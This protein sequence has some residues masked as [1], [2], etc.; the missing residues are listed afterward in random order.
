M[1]RN[2]LIITRAIAPTWWICALWLLLAEIAQ[3]TIV[4]YLRIREVPPSFV[5]VTVIWYAIRVDSQR[6]VAFAL[7][8][9][10][11]ED[12]L[13]QNTGGAWTLSTTAAA[14]AVSLASRGFFADSIPLV[15]VITAATTLVTMFVFWIVMGFEGFPGGLAMIH[16]H[17]ALIEALYNAAVMVIVMLIGR[18]FDSRYA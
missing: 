18:R 4:H 10:L 14:L 9:G 16:F 11:L 5:L 7:G 6:A 2:K 15:A 17:E 8:A 13:A 3:T 1:S 12:I